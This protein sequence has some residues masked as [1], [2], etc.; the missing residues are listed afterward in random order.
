MS[1]LSVSSPTATLTTNHELH[2][3]MPRG[4]DA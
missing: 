2:S 3:P 4:N 1:L